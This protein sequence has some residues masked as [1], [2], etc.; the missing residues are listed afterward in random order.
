MEPVI[1]HLKAGHRLGRNWPKGLFGDDVNVLFAAAGK[2]IR[3]LLHAC[4][5]IFALLRVWAVIIRCFALTRLQRQV[6]CR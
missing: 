3:K 2:N 1:G 6:V 4:A 5:G